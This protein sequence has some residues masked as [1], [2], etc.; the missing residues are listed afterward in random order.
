MTDIVIALF[1]AVHTPCMIFQFYLLHIHIGL[2]NASGF[3]LANP[4]FCAWALIPVTICARAIDWA[5][6]YGA[7]QAWENVHKIMRAE[8]RMQQAKSFR[9]WLKRDTR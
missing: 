7:E 6:G 2:R 9:E 5:K 1:L 4:L 3:Q 8:H